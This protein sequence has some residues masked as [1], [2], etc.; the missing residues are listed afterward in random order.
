MKI[1]GQAAMEF[2][3]TYGIAILIIVSVIVA[4]YAMGVF[5]IGR[6]GPSCSPCFPAGTEFQYKDHSKDILVLANGPY[7]ITINRVLKDNTQVTCSDPTTFPSSYEP[8]KD[9]TLRCA[10]QFAGD[11]T[12]IIEYNRTPDVLKNVTATLHGA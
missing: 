1:K 4:L 6:G 11:V 5:R 12:I 3:M 2:L 7:E 10:G 8:N 9:I